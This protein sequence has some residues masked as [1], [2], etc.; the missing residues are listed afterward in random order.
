MTRLQ[1]LFLWQSMRGT[2]RDDEWCWLLHGLVHPTDPDDIGNKAHQTSGQQRLSLL[3]MSLLAHVK[4]SKSLQQDY[5][6]EQV[7][8]DWLLNV[9]HTERVIKLE[10]FQ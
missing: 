10:P 4:N 2:T 3:A 7:P 9:V 5:A 6:L 1:H 8:D